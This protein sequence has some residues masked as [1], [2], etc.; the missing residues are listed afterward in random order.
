MQ[1]EITTEYIRKLQQESCD[2]MWETIISC[3]RCINPSLPVIHEKLTDEIKKNPYATEYRIHIG[4]LRIPISS[5]IDAD[6]ILDEFLNCYSTWMDRYVPSAHA[7]VT[8]T[9]F[10]G[11]EIYFVFCL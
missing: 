5:S 10:R 3:I 1:T 8:V 2:R 9:S 7:D 4:T 11:A 6:D